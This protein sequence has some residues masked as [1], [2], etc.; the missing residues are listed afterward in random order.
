MTEQNMLVFWYQQTEGFNTSKVVILVNL[1][2]GRHGE[3]LSCVME[4]FLTTLSCSNE[5]NYF[6]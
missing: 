1:R 3:L 5:D 4:V 6:E 2:G